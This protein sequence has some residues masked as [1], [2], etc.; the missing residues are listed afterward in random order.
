MLITW[1][2][3]GLAVMMVV[4][5]V[6]MIRPSV[7]QKKTASLRTAA[8]EAGLIV[9]LGRSDFPESNGAIYTLPW[10]EE[11][12]AYQRQLNAWAL[13]KG[14]YEHDIH[15]A[16]AWDWQGKQPAADKLWPLIEGTIQPLPASITAF[17]MNN[18]GVF[19]LWNEGFAAGEHLHAID[20]IKQRLVALQ[21]GILDKFRQA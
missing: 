2:V 6:M 4:G 8:S 18:V 15:F 20:D 19:M 11:A 9:K 17:G 5:P 12:K 13:V 1:V 16:G 14:K 3:I 7:S 10:P 21:E